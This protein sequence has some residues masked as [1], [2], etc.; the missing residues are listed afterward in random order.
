MVVIGLL[1]LPVVAMVVVAG[2]FGSTPDPDFGGVPPDDY[3]IASYIGVVLASLGLVTLPVHIATNRELG[4]T[5]RFRASG[6]SAGSLVATQL[7][8]GV[9]LGVVSTAIVLTTGALLYDIGA[10]LD[11]LGV[12]AWYAAGL[13]CFIAIGGA[14]GLLAPT[15]RAANAIG[16]LLFIPAL[17]LG[18][19]GPPR[20]VMTG[21]MQAV[22]DAIPLS[23]IT[24]GLR[25][26][27]LGTTDAS[28]VWW[29]PLVVCATAVGA[30][31]WV[32]RRRVG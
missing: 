32:A 6:V 20:D 28:I 12:A 29:W 18:G 14:L 8:L 23:H 26:A 30:S 5:R 16:N 21:G 31:L 13:G 1:C 22:A 19:G 2:V 24:G 4:V 25:Q 9:V 27:W 3:Y 7:A 15:G 11:W 10:P 17:L